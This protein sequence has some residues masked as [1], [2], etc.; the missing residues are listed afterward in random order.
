VKQQQRA[1]H[2][3]QCRRD[4]RR[5]PACCR[6]ARASTLDSGGGRPERQRRASATERL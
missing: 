5:S 3:P 2:A 1:E 6:C 4:T